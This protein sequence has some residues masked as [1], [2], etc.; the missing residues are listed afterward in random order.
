ME[1]TNMHSFDSILFNR[2][3]PNSSYYLEITSVPNPRSHKDISGYVFDMV[4]DADL[5]NFKDFVDEVVEKYPPRFNEQ[6]TI[7][8]YDLASST[9]LEVKS[10]QE[11]LQMFAKH[12]D[13]KTVNMFFS[14]NLPNET[15]QWPTITASQSTQPTHEPN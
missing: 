15:P 5:T 14:C 8:Y 3:D 4:V 11:L 7:A 1:S 6:P 10:Y 12:A 9:Y 13:T 2:M